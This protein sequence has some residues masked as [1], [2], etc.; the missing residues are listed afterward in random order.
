M[1]GQHQQPENVDDTLLANLF[2]VDNSCA[3]RKSFVLV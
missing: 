1:Y 3:N 2:P